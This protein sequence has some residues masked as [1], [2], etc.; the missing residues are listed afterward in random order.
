MEA[1]SR[2]RG[3]THS[4]EDGNSRRTG[5]GGGG[6]GPDVTAGRSNGNSRGGHL[7]TGVAVAA[8]TRFSGDKGNSRGG[9]GGGVG[10]DSGESCTYR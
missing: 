10:G 8:P 4:L 7:H 5:T 1:A 2:K 9:S 6:T 3:R